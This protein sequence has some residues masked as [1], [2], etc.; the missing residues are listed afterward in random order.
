MRNETTNDASSG[1]DSPDK[2]DILECIVDG[3]I[4]LDEDW[5]ISY[6]NT[7]VEQQAQV[8]LEDVV[9]KLF[10]QIFHESKGTVL[11]ESLR[12]VMQTGKPEAMELFYPRY[13]QW[14]A[15]KISP[16]SKGGVVIAFRDI[17]ARKRLEILA[18]SQ[19]HA[20]E[21]ALTGEPLSTVLQVLVE[22]VKDQAGH[23]AF[24]AILLIDEQGTDL[25]LGAA[26]DCA[27]A[28]YQNL[29]TSGITD[30]HASCGTAVFTQKLVITEDIARDPNWA[31]L[32]ELALEQDLRA[33]W[34]MPI[35]SSKSQKILGAFSVYY[36]DVRKPVES[37]LRA[38]EV[39]ARTAAIS[40]ERE[41]ENQSRKNAEVAL[42]VGEEKLQRQRR[43]Y[44]TALS[45]TPDLVYIFD[46]DARFTYANAALLKMWGL[47]WEDAIGKTCLE[48]GYEPWHAEMHNRE[49]A[50][51]IATKKPIRGDVP[52][53]GTLGRRIYDYIFV[54]VLGDD[55][56]VEAIAGTTR[57]VT[58]RKHAEEVARKSE[59]RQRLALKASHSFG[60]WDWDITNNVLTTDERIGSLFGLSSE[61]AKAGVPVE[62]I[63]AKVHPDDIERVETAIKTA[64]SRGSLYREEYRIL[65]SDGSSRWISARGHAQM[66]DA[67]VAIRFPGVG[68]D[69]TLEK[70]AINRLR[71]ADHKK[72]EFLAMLA[73]ELRNPLAPIRNA[74]YMLNSEKFDRAA[75]ERARDLIGRQVDHMV[76]LVDDLM[77]VS[78]I[79]R[80][81]I[82][83]RKDTHNLD[84]ILQNA[85]ETAQPLISERGH[86]L[87]THLPSEP[88]YVSGDLI[89]LSQVF[90]NL[91][92]NAAKY[93]EPG[94]HI[95]IETAVK[96]LLVEIRITDSG[97]GIDAATLPNIFDMFSQAENSLER[98]QGGLGIGLTLV[99]RLVELHGG[100][101][102][103]AS[104]GKNKG[105]QFLVTLP[106]CGTKEE[107]QQTL[108]KSNPAPQGN[109][110]L[111]ILVVDDNVDAAQTMAWVLEAIDCSVETAFTGNEALKLAST[112][113]PDVLML[114][115]GMP[116]MNGYQL[117]EKL[118]EHP[119]LKNSVFIA[120]TGWGQLDHR[121]KSAKAGFDHHLVKPLNLQDLE[122]I[123]SSIRKN[124]ND[125]Q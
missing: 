48:L 7:R 90:S 101:I 47:P 45:N 77:D 80:G 53:T 14:N 42:N 67:G 20:M 61:E 92:N 1:A 58:E 50:Q 111:K 88:V 18:V 74:L 118:R 72:D 112:F 116:E 119:E 124:K 21:L 16:L 60:I 5:R 25:H 37:D 95:S 86:Q 83:L 79:T 117:C 115:I 113:L 93:T 43:L 9:G 99:K 30:K 57:D 91:L 103:A 12:T 8:I 55:G 121:Q 87:S 105:S 107:I 17:S 38:V 109:T 85:V 33:C 104:D 89:R 71:D 4:T 27:I 49:I 98:S 46:L 13:D 40:I 76:H 10:F 73:H 96:D 52:F 94:G 69:I 26:S 28:F 110:R 31:E 68:V 51:V 125:A 81:K 56:E 34:S 2:G 63:L 29:E 65:Q 106:M 3:I 84:A 102:T 32:R 6:I 22:A 11:E 108:G 23:K 123:L 114:D 82:K 15:I 19:R 70:N 35:F 64:V 78:R 36:P 120:Q 41:Q 39:L 54:P 59:E 100:V 75:K 62:R 24:A 97:I 122:P 66:N 44:E